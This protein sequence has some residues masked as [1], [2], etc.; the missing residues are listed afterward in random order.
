[1]PLT[2]LDAFGNFWDYSFDHGLVIVF[3]NFTVERRHALLL[4]I[5]L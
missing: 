1:M 2:L 3:E 4:K 5:L